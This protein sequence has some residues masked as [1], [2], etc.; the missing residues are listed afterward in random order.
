MVE[1]RR[2]LCR[3][4]VKILSM[5]MM[6]AAIRNWRYALAVAGALVC[7]TGGVVHQRYFS[8]LGFNPIAGLGGAMVVAAIPTQV[9]RIVRVSVPPSKETTNLD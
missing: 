8:D 1:R 3:L 5:A 2:N 6:E 4:P 9:I 7:F